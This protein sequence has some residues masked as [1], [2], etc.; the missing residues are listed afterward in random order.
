[1]PLAVRDDR[2]DGM[3]LVTA[4]R[5]GRSCTCILG[6]GACAGC[7]LGGIDEQDKN[8]IER[9]ARN[10]NVNNYDGFKESTEKNATQK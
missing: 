3:R 7:V 2:G 10:E 5:S 9:F 8:L 6:P 4:A 1:M